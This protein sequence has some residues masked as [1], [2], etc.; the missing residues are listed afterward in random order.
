MT[1]FSDVVVV[2]S[3][4]ESDSKLAGS[5][6]SNSEAAGP[7][8]RLNVLL[9]AG[10]NDPRMLLVRLFGI[11]ESSLPNDPLQLWGLLLTLLAEPT[12][13]RRLRRI[14]TL[15]KVIELLN[16]CKSILVVTGAGISVSCGIP[17]FRSRDGVYARLSKDYP[18][19]SSP[20]AMFDMAYFVQNPSPFFKFAKVSFFF[21]DTLS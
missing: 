12:P 13:R 19:L 1:D 14:N 4:E 20:Q 18:D 5:E 6:R 16:T 7:F 2:S 3:E 11:E 15:D 9:R 21:I 17:D 8:K 10:H